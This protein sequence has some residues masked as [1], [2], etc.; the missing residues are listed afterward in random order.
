MIYNKHK[1]WINMN[2]T[3]IADVYGTSNNGTSVTCN[4]LA[5][6]MVERGHNVT[7][8]STNKGEN[9]SGIKYIQLPKRK[10]GGLGFIVEK[11]GVELAKPDREKIIEGIK[12]AD[13][14][15]LLVCFKTSIATIPILKE[16]KKP[17]TS[18]FHTQPENVTAHFGCMNVKFIN[19]ALYR[20]F[21]KKFYDKALFLHAPSQFL[22]D[23]L[24][25]HGY[26]NRFYVI[27]NGVNPKF[28]PLEN[29]E[30]P[31]SM[32]DKFVIVNTGRYCKE[33]R[34]KL[35]IDAVAQSKHEKDI[36]LI[37]LGQGPDINKL[38]RRA[39]K[40]TNYPVFGYLP[41][42]DFLDALNYGDLYVHPSNVELEGISCLEAMAC[43]LP[44]IFS[45]SE[46]SAS[47][48]FAKDDRCLFKH[49]N[50]KDLA[51]KIDYLF[52]N[53]KER[54]ELADYYLEY[55]KNFEM[56]SAMDKM[57]QMFKDAI[58]YYTNYYQ[59]QKN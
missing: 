14:V 51:K 10:F 25:K 55:S 4:N 22:V 6:R 50:A 48:Y 49:D 9:E 13:V 42:K 40:L 30:K 12:D 52:E 16:Y 29:V 47:R 46:N 34:T 19:N 21:K 32:K 56:N 57:E 43:G 7:I 53:E 41:F 31:E 58:E 44:C 24:K 54:K 1:G 17:F 36:Q 39:K 23:T 38:K 2:I 59:N 27:S 33:K 8:V 3:I 45:D 11:N 15:H 26:T 5:R 18:A 37:C 35:L 28:K 20:R